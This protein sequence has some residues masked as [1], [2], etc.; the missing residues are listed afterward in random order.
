MAASRS[1]PGPGKDRVHGDPCPDS[2]HA[3]PRAVRRFGPF[4]LSLSLFPVSF[5]SSSVREPPN[6]LMESDATEDGRGARESV[7][8]TVSKHNN[9]H[10]DLEPR[11]DQDKALPVGSAEL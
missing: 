10:F 4:P 8:D 11:Q 1:R 3:A 7:K 5:F 9:K 2:L 6:A